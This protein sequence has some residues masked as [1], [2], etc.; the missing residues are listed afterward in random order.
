MPRIWEPLRVK[1]REG[2][3]SSNHNV[4]NYSLLVKQEHVFTFNVSY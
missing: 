1:K 4:S 2:E 3:I